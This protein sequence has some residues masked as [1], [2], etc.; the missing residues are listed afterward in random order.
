MDTEYTNKADIHP[1]G[2]I[3]LI[4][5]A[6]IL[7]K[8]GWKMIQ[9][10]LVLDEKTKGGMRTC[11]KAS[12]EWRAFMEKKWQTPSYSQNFTFRNKITG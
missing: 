12:K 4:L 11:F 6:K 7:D 2:N 10:E 8:A 5:C 1:G 3:P 9:R